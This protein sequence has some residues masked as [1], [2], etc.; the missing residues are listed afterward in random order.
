M[1]AVF[2]NIDT[3]GKPVP[4]FNLRGQDE[5][6]TSIGGVLTCLIAVLMLF[7][8]SI[9]FEQLIIRHNPTLS[10]YTEFNRFD[11]NDRLSLNEINFRFAFSVEGYHSKEMK[12]DPRYV[13]YLVRVFGIKEGQ[14]YETFIPYHKCTD[15]DWAQFRPPAT[16]SADSWTTIKDDPKRGFY[17]LDWTDDILLYG[18]EK[19]E[20]YQRIEVVLTPCNYLHT[21]LGFEGDSIHPD[22]VADLYK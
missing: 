20:D 4:M 22:C 6:R 15:S 12:N 11:L 17:C 1:Q 18:N 3:F 19:N 9:K 10:Q 2:R 8:A 21:H 16:A 5:I 7:Y 14:E 13:K